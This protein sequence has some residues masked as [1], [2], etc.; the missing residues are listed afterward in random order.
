MIWCFMSFI[1]YM[2]EQLYLCSNGVS[3]FNQVSPFS[4]LPKCFLSSFLLSHL[5]FIQMHS[6]HCLMGLTPILISFHSQVHHSSTHI[7]LSS[8]YTSVPLQSPFMRFFEISTIFA[9]P[10]IL[11]LLIQSL[12]VTPHIYLTILISGTSD[13]TSQHLADIMKGS[14]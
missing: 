13:F 9:I 3:V 10:L 6:L 12:L 8:H 4:S 11:S 2:S 1:L 14:Q 7:V 5:M